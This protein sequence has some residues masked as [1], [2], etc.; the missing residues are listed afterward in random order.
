MAKGAAE[1]QSL[2]LEPS[3]CAYGKVVALA[4]G[5]T[6][7]QSLKRDVHSGLTNIGYDSHTNLTRGHSGSNG[8]TVFASTDPHFATPQ[9]PVSFARGAGHLQ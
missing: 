9:Q 3:P 7:A 4:R 5:R 8:L 1:T 2:P 6:M